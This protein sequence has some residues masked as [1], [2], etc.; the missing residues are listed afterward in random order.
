MIERAFRLLAIT[1]VLAGAACTLD[2]V[3]APELTGP[4]T[5]ATSLV[6]T[7]NP[8]TVVLNGQQSLVI[9]QARDASGAPLPSLKVHLDLFAG[10]SDTAS[11][12]GRLSSTDI[13]TGSDGRSSVVFTA[14]NVPLPMPECSGFDGFITVVATAVGTNAQVS[15]QSAAAIRLLTPSSLSTPST[16]AVNFSMA[17][18][19]ANV[20]Q[21]VNFSDAGSVSPGHAIVGYVW[22]FGDGTTKSGPN[23][24]HDFGARGTYN[25]TLTITDDIGQSGF[26]TALLQIN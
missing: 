19:P 2:G 17:P 10:G 26:K 6:L 7:A 8:D 12:C 15:N 20:N 24:A 16:F 18:N 25:V 4:S 3:T 14:P 5:A 22:N 9:V 1:T 11:S 23:V 21:L 13:T